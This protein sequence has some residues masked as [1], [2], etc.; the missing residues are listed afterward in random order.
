MKTERNNATKK[1][2]DYATQACAGPHRAAIAG[3]PASALVQGHA[4]LVGKIDFAKRKSTNRIR[5]RTRSRIAGG[6]G[7]RRGQ[8]GW[9]LDSEQFRST[10]KV[11][12]AS[13]H[14]HL[15][16][17]TLTSRVIGDKGLF[18]RVSN[19]GRDTGA[20]K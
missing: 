13:M 17:Q 9:R 10:P 3:E 1:R 8:A 4:N 15:R 2:G 5:A 14:K 20:E 7:E 16:C 18:R 12:H 19:N 6:G 11:P